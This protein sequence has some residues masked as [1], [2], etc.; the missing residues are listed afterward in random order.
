M[1]GDMMKAV[2]GSD[3]HK[4]V[5]Q[6]LNTAPDH[7]QRFIEWLDAV[8]TTEVSGE[9]E[10]MNEELQARKIQETHRTSKSIAM[11]NTWTRYNRHNV[12]LK[13]KW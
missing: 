8:I 6:E 13:Q 12:Q 7:R 3:E 11:K 10:K 9:L 5:W 4:E 2:F 1:D